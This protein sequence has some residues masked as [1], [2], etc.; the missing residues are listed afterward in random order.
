MSRVVRSLAL[1]IQEPTAFRC[2]LLIAGLHYS[3]Q[4][5]GMKEFESTY[6]FHKGESIRLINN[7]VSD[8]DTRATA[9]C[10]QLISTL[11]LA[12]VPCQA[13]SG[14]RSVTSTDRL[15]SEFHWRHTNGGGTL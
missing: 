6:L 2:A 1:S 5:G 9:D 14:P 11:V 13:M 7:W 12:E 10:M 3:W 4:K 8:S 15:P